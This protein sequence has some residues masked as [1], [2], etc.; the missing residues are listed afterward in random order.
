MNRRLATVPHCK[1][2][3]VLLAISALWLL[4]ANPT[5][6]QGKD[7]GTFL[8][9][10]F[11][12]VTDNA[13]FAKRI[14]GYGYADGVSVLAAWVDLNDSVSFIRP[15][16][17]G[18][19]YTFLAAGD[20]DAKIVNLDILDDKGTK[21]LKS[22]GKKQPDAV[23]EFTP[24][25]SG[26]YTMR[27]TLAQSRNNYPCMC[28]AT[29]LKKDGW[30]VPLGNLDTCA[31]KITDALTAVDD[32]LRTKTGNRLDFL[33]AK[34]Q[35]A[36][37]GGILKQ[38]ETLQ[39]DNMTLGSGMKGFIAVGDNNTQDVDLFLL[40]QNGTTIKEDT[41]TDPVAAFVHEPGPQKHSL[42]ALNYKATAPALVFM[43]TFDV[44][45]K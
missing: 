26:N 18:V 2:A 10:A 45:G 4:P 29:I 42:R 35:W 43:S 3:A 13:D 9:Q 7:S 16:T 21:V 33:K 41:R 24:A 30:K 32:D 5:S 38:S 6:G 17:G 22:D 44:K 12:R 27:L 39:V 15:L 14:T 1:S 8:T 34:N 19:S 31:K 37:Y 23:L 25:A 28:V 11:I 36:L 20:K 40:D